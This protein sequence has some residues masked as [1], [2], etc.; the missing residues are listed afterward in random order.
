[1][2]IYAH[3]SKFHGLWEN[4][5]YDIDIKEKVFYMCALTLNNCSLSLSLTHTHTH[6]NH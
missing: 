4:L 5:V 6:M 3:M 1:M 2:S